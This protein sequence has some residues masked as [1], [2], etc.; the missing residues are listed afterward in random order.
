MFYLTK[1]PQE[2]QHIFPENKYTKWYFSIII[3]AMPRGLKKPSIGS[4]NYEYYEA[5]HILPRCEFPEAENFK[6]C[7]WNKV[8][9]TPEEHFTCHILLAKIFK[10]SRKLWTAAYFMTKGNNTNKRS[11]KAYGFIRRNMGLEKRHILKQQNS[12]FSF[13]NRSHST[14]SKEQISRNTS[15]ALRKTIAKKVYQFDKNGTLL[16]S[17]ETVRDAAKHISTNASNITY[18]CNHKF[19]HC[20]G[21]IWEWSDSTDRTITTIHTGRNSK[22]FN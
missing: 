2:Y 3:R 19:K 1:I 15:A 22:T 16:S 13:K 18:T 21:F 6:K 17:F 8:L 12:S 7:P 20:K 5:H 11:N 10:N 14:E 9:L 4:D